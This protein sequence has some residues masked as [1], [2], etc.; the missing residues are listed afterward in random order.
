[1]RTIS[2]SK[3]T[4][5]GLEDLCLNPG[6]GRDHC[7]HHHVQIS[8]G[9][10]SVSYL[11]C[12]GDVKL[13]TQVLK[14]KNMCGALPPIP[15]TSLWYG[16]YPRDNF[17]VRLLFVRAEKQWRGFVVQE[18]DLEMLKLYYLILILNKNTFEHHLM[19]LTKQVWRFM[20]Q[21]LRKWRQQGH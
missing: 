4:G 6:M 9:V 12:T 19:G 8:S 1:M 11:I 7:L 18:T 2:I 10:H 20:A 3:V 16:S 14:I 17:T 5:Y 13:T 21:N 15:H